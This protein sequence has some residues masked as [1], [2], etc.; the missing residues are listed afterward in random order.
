MQLMVHDDL[1]DQIKP[2]DRVEVCGIYRASG[3][4]V[5]SEKRTQNSIFRT[6]VD[7][8]IF[9]KADKKRF[10]VDVNKQ[11]NPAAEE[12]RNQ[13]EQNLNFTEQQI[14]K[15][16]AFSKDPEL[17]EKLT[18]AIAPSIWEQSDVKKG[19]LCQ[20]FGG[21]Q[22]SFEQSGRGRFR[23][24]INVLLVGDPST[25]KSQILQYVHKIAPRGIYT[26]GKGSSAVGLTVYITKDPETKE[27]VLESGALVLS[28]RGICC[29]DEFDKMDDNTRVILHE[30]M[31]QQTV[32]VA[33]AGIICTLNARTAILAAANPVGSKYNP[34]MS[35]VDNI[36]LP[37][38][39]LSRFDLI[40]L[41][42]DS[43]TQ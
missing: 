3:V 31:E 17:F 30:A 28:D 12:M 43:Q 37:P 29:I 18:N 41:M 6:Y 4:R 36:K 14:N 10:H 2:G 11:D 26:S 39:L 23:G 40:Y 1:V 21:S 7:V 13:E 27:T 15:F 9:V 25:A 35:V 22:K 8:V 24:E 34:K 19:V 5:N 32:S 42:L 20:L 33:K 38:T 16:K